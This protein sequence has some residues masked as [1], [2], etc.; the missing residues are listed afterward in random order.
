MENAWAVARERQPI[1]IPAAQPL[2]VRSG[3]GGAE[4]TGTG[5]APQTRKCLLVTGSPGVFQ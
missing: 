4:C 2:G 3:A 1:Y 5:G